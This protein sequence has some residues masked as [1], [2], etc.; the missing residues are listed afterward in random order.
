MNNRIFTTSIVIAVVASG[1]SQSPA[2]PSTNNTNQTTLKEDGKKTNRPNSLIEDEISC[3]YSNGN[4]FFI[5]PININSGMVSV[6][7]NQLGIIDYVDMGNNSI[8]IPFKSGLITIEF[9]TD[10]GRIFSGEMI[11]SDNF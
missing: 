8:Y 9:I 2:N 6:A 5:F 4:L 11:I 7:H 1:F 10:D 3:H